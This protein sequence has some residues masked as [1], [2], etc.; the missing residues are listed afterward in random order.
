MKPCAEVMLLAHVKKKERKKALNDLDHLV[1]TVV[2]PPPNAPLMK[3]RLAS[4]GSCAADTHTHSRPTSL[5]KSVLQTRLSPVDSVCV[6][7]PKSPGLM[8][9]RDTSKNP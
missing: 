4:L 3:D 2:L 7:V 6:C 8:G 1:V 5:S 9:C